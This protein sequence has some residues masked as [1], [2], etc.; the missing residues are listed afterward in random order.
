MQR[1]LLAFAATAAAGRTLARRSI[2][3][4]LALPR[5][6]RPVPGPAG[7]EW[8]GRHAPLCPG[9]PWFVPSEHDP[10]AVAQPGRKDKRAAGLKD[11]ILRPQT[12]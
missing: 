7:R 5:D 12:F 4:S 11:K 3:L 6:S 8:E 10:C 9:G 2:R 1:V